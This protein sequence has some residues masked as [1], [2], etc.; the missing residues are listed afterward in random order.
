MSR[1]SL[2]ESFRGFVARLASPPGWLGPVAL[3][4]ATVWATDFWHFKDFGLYEDD[5]TFIP[6]AI[7]MEFPELVQFI[8]TYLVRLYGHGR[9]LSDSF[10][11]LFSFLGW[12]V[13]GLGAVYGIGYLLVALNAILFYALLRRLGDELLALT[14]GLAFA[15][16]PADTTQP[17]L[18]HS[19]GLQPSLT[20]LLLAAHVYLSRRRWGAY[21][22][23]MGSL[24]CYETVFPVFLAVPLLRGHFDRQ[25]AR[26]LLL[27][28]LAMAGMLLAVVSLRLLVGETRVAGLEV[29][30]VILTP[31][32]HMA[33]GPLVTFA[34]YFIRPVQTVL[35]A[36]TQ[37][38]AVAAIFLVL[39]SIQLGRSRA[40]AGGTAGFPGVKLVWNQ[41]RS[42]LS[43]EAGLLTSPEPS[44]LHRIQHLLA[45]LA[46]LVLAYSLTFDLRSFSIAGRATRVHFAAVVGASLLF[47]ALVSQLLRASRGRWTRRAS[48]L[49]ISAW[50]AVLVAY[51]LTVQRDYV[52][53]WRAQ[54]AFWS[55]IVELVPDVENGSIILIEA[56]GLRDFDQIDANT[57]NLPR[58]LNQIYEFP[59]DWDN[60]PRVY[61][62][63]PGW[64]DYIYESRSTLGLYQLT[65]TAPPSLY[66]EVEPSQTVLIETS[67]DKL[68]RR[69]EPL[70]L[71]EGLVALKI[72]SEAILPGMDPGFLH[73]LLSVRL[74]VPE[75]YLTEG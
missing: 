74:G 33:V 25:K 39:I 27:H 43:G 29:P 45:G 73:P 31:I 46:M 34:T 61:R 5:F 35:L 18:T 54:Q 44:V 59:A 67:T 48:L 2:T 71:P 38:Y 13:A 52:Q 56:S 40:N 58:L 65:V 69:D 63:V 49:G 36:A 9:P 70:A 51:G 42:R 19:L 21:L 50:L 1:T 47:A 37:E 26:E 68:V 10:I 32:R 23:V 41:F 6:Q 22:I 75:L 53:A 66:R 28:A 60:P 7:T 8:G 12:R 20:F 62:L 64:Q 30:S 15:V 3:L 55:D 24:F 14:G 57:W 4:L 11:S 16:F 72:P 17:F